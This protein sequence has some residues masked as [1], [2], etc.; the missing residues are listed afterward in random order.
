MFLAEGGLP[1]L[2]LVLATLV[3]GTLAPAAPTRS[4]VY[5]RDIDRLMHRT[6]NRP[7]VTGEVTPREALVFGVV[8]PR[9]RRLVRRS[10]STCCPR[11]SRLAAILF[12]VVVYTL[13]L[14]R[15]TPQNIVWGGA[16]GCMPVLIGWA[17]VTGTVPGRR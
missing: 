1:P 17:A 10:R 2:W 16:A 13:L 14:K 15:R 8:L 11:S 9:S 6:S 12:Y 4:T 5:D 3:G 7:L